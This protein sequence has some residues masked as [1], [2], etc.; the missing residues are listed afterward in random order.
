[1]TDILDF[2]RAKFF[3]K[4]IDYSEDIIRTEITELYK[5][6]DPII[7]ET[8]NSLKEKRVLASKNTW[9]TS[10]DIVITNVLLQYSAIWLVRCV[11]VFK[12]EVGDSW[13]LTPEEME[14]VACLL[15][16]EWLSSE[17]ENE[18]N[19]LTKM[20]DKFMDLLK[21]S[22][23]TKKCAEKEIQSNEKTRKLNEDISRE[24]QNG[25]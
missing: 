4:H 24:I 1:M 7:K 25:K 22:D 14:Q 15:L 5:K 23:L 3:K 9:V 21:N 11:D 19:F 8:Y 13:N 6:I 18:R 16:S 12:K 2:E 17:I 20:T 10:A